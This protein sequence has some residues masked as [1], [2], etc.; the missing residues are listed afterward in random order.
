[1]GFYAES[2]QSLCIF[3]FQACYFCVFVF[4]SM[5]TRCRQL[6]SR[7]SSTVLLG[8]V[9]AG[10]AVIGSASTSHAQGMPLDSVL[11]R[12]TAAVHNPALTAELHDLIPSYASQ[13]VWGLSLG[14]FSNDSLADIAISLY[15]LSLGKNQVR[16]FFLVNNRGQHLQKVFDRVIPYIESPIEV[17]LTTD[18]SVITLIQK[19]S[20]QHWT[21]DGYSFEAGDLVLVD[22]FETDREEL[23]GAKAREL[24]HDRYRNYENL[25]TR[26]TY[27]AGASGEQL[28]RVQY[29]TFP[30]YQR[31]RDVYPGY[32]FGMTDTTKDFIIEGLG[33][34]KDSRDL[35]IA[36]A[37]TAYDDDY[38]YVSMSIN[39]DYVVGNGAT[40]EAND[41]ITLWFDTQ[42]KG[43][44]RVK[45]KQGGFPTFRNAIDSSV[46]SITLVVPPAQGKV[47]KVEYSDLRPLTSIQQEAIKNIKAQMAF[48]TVNGLVKGY[49]MRARI[50]FTF[51]G[52]EAN[53]L[54]S[55]DLRPSKTTTSASATNA[56]ATA[57]STN[58]NGTRNDDDQLSLGFTA[59]VYDVDDPSRPGE[60]TVQA[61][62]EYK[63]ADPST[64]GTLIF[65]PQG[66]FYG[67]VT[68]TY[69]SSLKD[70][71]V[72]AG[73]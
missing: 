26:E 50:P 48:D 29:A 33:Q 9:V 53:P 28:Y 60:V 13:R 25:R 72:K 1:M 2:F 66:L 32:G 47:T 35:S 52:F 36:R 12:I 20:D 58:E 11:G 40:D 22:H 18:G 30:S 71:I 44:R 23:K 8:A 7:L 41:R 6:F 70:A 27:F 59:L 38:L 62:S 61:T 68:P 57:S 51:L 73:Y 4:L 43:D 21:Q 14:D 3:S 17:G 67:E 37:M 69:I 65:E 63:K 49:T 45:S 54:L 24:G 10:A 46:Y 42:V 34:R 5:I 15:D 64:F 31:L 39:D 55:L 19:I 56:N 16:V